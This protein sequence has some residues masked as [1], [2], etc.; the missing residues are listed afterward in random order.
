MPS[1]TPACLPEMRAPRARPTAASDCR[2]LVSGLP[3]RELW[4]T[5]TGRP[6]TDMNVGREHVD[7]IAI[8]RAEARDIIAANSTVLTVL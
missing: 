7:A 4:D 5:A 1:A 3:A 8:G 6:I 2:G